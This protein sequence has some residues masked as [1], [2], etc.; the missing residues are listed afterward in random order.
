VERGR[1]TFRPTFPVAPRSFGGAFLGPFLQHGNESA[2]MVITEEPGE[3]RAIARRELRELGCR[4]MALATTTS[5]TKARPDS[6]Q[7]NGRSPG[8]MLPWPR[9]L[10][11]TRHAV[12]SLTILSGA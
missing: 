10:R 1:L 3:S 12:Q 4:E 6:T 8:F 7:P 9:P 5:R 2:V 11:C